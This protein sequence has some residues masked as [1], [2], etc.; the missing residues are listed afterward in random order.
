M[1]AFCPKKHK[2]DLLFVMTEQLDFFVLEWDAAKG[3]LKT[4]TSGS[5]FDPVGLQAQVPM[6]C[7]DPQTRV[8]AIHNNVG[9]LRILEL[10]SDTGSVR[11][12][13]SVRTPDLTLVDMRFLFG[14]AN[15][16]PT[17]AVLH[18]DPSTAVR[19]C[20]AP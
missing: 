6:A 1:Q 10:D 3:R 14:S 15:A 13:F 5:A 20:G 11:K 9:K 2:Q 12:Q 18:E 17:L 19:R 16:L 7:V 8:I 4:V